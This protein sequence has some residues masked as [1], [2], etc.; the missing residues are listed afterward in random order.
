M[1]GILGILER[2][3][4]GRDLRTA[5]AP[6]LQALKKRGPDG[7]G[8][9]LDPTGSIALGHRRLAIIDLSE[10]GL[11]PMLSADGRLAVTFNGEIF[12]FREL[13]AELRAQGVQF[14]SDSDTEVLL[15]LY[16]AHGPRMVEKLRGM[17]AFGLWDAAA[18]TLLLARDPYG[19]KPLYYTNDGQ[20]LCFSS[21]VRALLEIG[22]SRAI[23]D[24]ALAGFYLFGSVPEPRTIARAVRA[25]PA[26]TTL[27]ATREHAG[28]PQPYFSIAREYAAA[29]ARATKPFD[30]NAA[31][32][33]LA[34]SV[35]H[36]LVADVPVG[37][38]LS[39]GID[40]GALL[41]LMR[42]VA[43]EAA[44][45]EAVTLV[46]TEN[47]G[48]MDDEGP[49]A[50]NVAERYRA[51]HVKRYVAREE[52]EADLPAF[53]AAMDQPTIDGINSWLVSKAAAER[54][55]KVALSGLGGDELLGG[56]PSFTDVPRW[57][58][59]LKPT[60]FAPR[61]LGATRA[62]LGPVLSRAGI[63]PKAQTLL[64]H[65]GTFEG[66]YLARR[67]LFTPWEL[68]ALMGPEAAARGLAELN[69]LEHIRS[70]MP[71]LSTAFGRVATLEAS[72]Y[73]RNQLLRDTDWASMAHSLE[74]RV[75]LVDSELLRALAP[76]AVRGQAT[77]QLL[78]RAPRKRLPDSVAFRPKTGFTTPVGTWLR[79]SPL[80]QAWRALPELADPR[81]HWARRYAYC[82]ARAYQE[83]IA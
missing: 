33:A 25:L 66:A 37:V 16:A 74:V 40:S 58:R 70:Q 50:G 26:G 73:M 15:H 5:L 32:A 60:R 6:G 22:V 45:I 24:A 9:W 39:A 1:C 59:L 83:Q 55:L 28:D 8:A 52:L 44:E 65:G 20:R 17:F 72:L 21:Q 48:T 10:R 81:T 63:S 53:F 61:A 14:R 51:Q 79:E 7:E 12:N 13:Q 43:G 38:F 78:A 27:I 31:R 76:D 2:E 29:E 46:F 19:I 47:V 23:D 42:D 82:V 57:T 35:R 34:D 3:P 56:Y 11:Q 18:G 30:E 4:S 36:H 80:L 62:L 71:G 64:A 54:G 77:K 41:G 75:P 69:P 67:G 49:L 68:P